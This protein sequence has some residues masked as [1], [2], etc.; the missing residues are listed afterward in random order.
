MLN[1]RFSDGV[2]S[3][4][5]KDGSNLIPLCE[6]RASKLENSEDVRTS[7]YSKVIFQTNL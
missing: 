4:L 5:K 2:Q 3:T 7:V 6:Q 1:F